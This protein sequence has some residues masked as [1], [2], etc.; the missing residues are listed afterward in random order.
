M[1]TTILFRMILWE[2]CKV[3]VISLLGITGILLIA[4]I[5]AEASQQGLGPTQ[6]LAA[7]PLLVPS[8]L[9]YTIPATTL[10]AACVVYGRLS[11]DNEVLAIK[12]CGVNV[13][14]VVKPGLVLGLVMSGA[15]LGLYYHVIPYT[16]HLLREMVFRDAEGM[17]YSVLARNGMISHVQMPYSMFV[18]GVQGKKLLNPVIKRRNA[19]GQIDL[20]AHAR[21]ADLR[22]D[23]ANRLLLIRMR[24]CVVISEDGDRGYSEDKKLDVPLEKIENTNRRAR[25]MTWV[26]LVQRRKDLAE[27]ME[28]VA[29]EIAAK[30]AELLLGRHAADLPKHVQN[31]KEKHKGLEHQDR[32][33]YV[34]MLMRPALSLGCL[35]FILVGCPIGIMF[36]R[37]DYLGAFITCF[38]PI[39]IVY[40]PL[41]L[42]GT[43]MAK[44]GRLNEV[45]LVFA[46]DLA[47]L[48]GSLSLFRWLLKH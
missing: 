4:G 19:K 24:H 38:L 7:I 21:E 16:H 11:A 32:L 29:E 17:L 6:I 34:E 48:V 47:V 9:P 28:D 10:F 42:A 22:V 15:T 46:A 18:K 37:G 26:E 8:T 27:E 25:D 23:T 39:V 45:V 36:S 40:Y 30:S 3:F 2:L 13:L 20:V 31:L 33:I 14:H 44:E 1:F 5:I 12:A 43:N 35:C 41:L